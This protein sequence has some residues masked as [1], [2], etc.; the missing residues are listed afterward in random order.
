MA[1]AADTSVC[2]FSST[3]TGA[4]SLSNV[5]GNLI[6]VLDACL[7]NGWGLVTCDSV[8][9]A[10][11]VGTATINAG[12]AAIPYGVVQFA[13]ATGTLSAVNGRRKVKSVTTTTVVFDAADLADGTVTGTI[14]MK[15]APA[16]WTK[17]FSGTNLAA[18]KSANVQASGALL[19][20]DDTTTTYAAVRG[21]E[22]MTSI[23]VG[24]GMFPLVSQ[25]ASSVW[26][27]SDAS[28]ARTW[29]IIANDRFIYLWVCPLASVPTL[30]VI[31]GAGDAVSRKR[32]DAYRFCLFSLTSTSAI[33][34]ASAYQ[35]QPI[36]SAAGSFAVAC[37]ARSYSGI[38]APSILG[39]TWLDAGGGY[40]GYGAKLFPNP[41]DNGVLLTDPLLTEGAAYRGGLPGVFSS[42]QMIGSG[43]Y[44]GQIINGL[45]GY[46]GDLI[47]KTWGY[48]ASARGGLFFDPVGPWSV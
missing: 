11:G 42:P 8:V 32:M 16:G 20:V 2:V 46:L 13:G 26:P 36:A 15:I 4:P 10:G 29:W 12:H 41:S 34:P 27:K 9:I 33:A 44:D 40:S 23:D 19:R 21:Y 39:K 37:A 5:A 14:A 18:Y 25:V 43:I 31:V 6:E 7:A 30:A 3:Q 35:Y 47:Y 1:A 24:S 48:D 22:A 45:V 38:G 17:A 28:T